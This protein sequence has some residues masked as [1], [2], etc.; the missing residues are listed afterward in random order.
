M[1]TPTSLTMA[2]SAIK[3]QSGST[4]IFTV[5]VHATQPLNG[6]VNLFDGT[7]GLAGFGVV[8]GTAVI[9]IGFLSVGTHVITAQYTGDANNLP[10]SASGP[11]NQVITGTTQM[12]LN[13]STSVLTH[14]MPINVT[15]Q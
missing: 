7:R 2:T 12:Y 11:L 15:I 4:V 8:N 1:R 5:T 6:D 13:G 9:P 3:A 10:S 14:Q